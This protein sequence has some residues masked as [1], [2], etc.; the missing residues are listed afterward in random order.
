M[1]II[2]GILYPLQLT[3]DGSLKTA[4]DAELIRGHI[5]SAIET[6]KQER[7]MQPSYGLP[8]LIFTSIYELPV[9]LERIRITLKS[10]ISDCEFQVTGSISDEGDLSVQINWSLGNI[11]MPPVQYRVSA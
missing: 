4:E 9:V 3:A 6:Y 2:R 11:T 5:Y 7:I 10:V 1:A 8:N